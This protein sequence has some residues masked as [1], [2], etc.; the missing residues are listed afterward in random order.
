VIWRR[1]RWAG[2]VVWVGCKKM[3]KNPEEFS[4]HKK[5]EDME[6]LEILIF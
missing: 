5:Y 6:L 1:I 2:H 3:S 4:E